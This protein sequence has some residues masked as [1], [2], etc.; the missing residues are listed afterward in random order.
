MTKKTCTTLRLAA[1]LLTILT[2]VVAAASSQAAVII[3]R[4]D[5]PTVGLPGFTTVTLT[6]S[7]DNGSNI[8]GFDFASKPSYGFFGPMNQVNPAGGATVF[9]D[10]NA[11]FAFLEPPVDLSRDSQFKFF[12]SQLT[13]PGGFASESN[14]K[15]RA[16][17]ASGVSLGASL[18]FVQLVIPEAAA[19]TVNYVGQ[20]QTIFGSGLPLDNNVSGSIPVPIPEPASAALVGL[21]VAIIGSCC[22]RQRNRQGVSTSLVARSLPQALAA[23]CVVM[24]IVMPARAVVI[25]SQSSSPTVGLPGFTTYTMTAT[26][27]TGS[28][29]G[30]DFASQPTF[31][32]FGPALNQIN[33]V[34][35]PTIFRENN[36]IFPFIGADPSQDSQF[37]FASSALT[38]PAGFA[39]ESNV[40]LRAVFAAGAPLG[41]SVQFAQLALPNSGG[42][43]QFQGQIQTVVG[44]VVSDNNVSGGCIFLGCGLSPPQMVDDIINNVNPNAPGLLTHTISASQIA[45]LSNFKFDSY[46][47]APGFSGT[48]PATAA[49]LNLSTREFRWNTV[50]SAPGTYKW[51]MT[52]GNT[53]G[54]DNGSLTV[55]VIPEPASAALAGLVVAIIA[56]N[57]RRRRPCRD[58]STSAAARSLTPAVAVLGV[59]SAILTFT[60]AAH[61]AVIIT[62]SGAPTVGLPNYTTY[63][64]TAT[65][66]IG[67]IQGFDFASQPSFGFFGAMNQ[68]NPAGI[69]TIFTDANAFFPF[70]GADVSQDSQ[71]KFASNAV[72]VPAGFASESA[73]SLRAVF[74]AS[75]PIGA[76][77]PF[78]QLAIPNSSGFFNFVGQIQTVVGGSVIDNNVTGSNCLGCVPPQIV[79]ATINNVNANNPGFVEHTV[80][81]NGIAGTLG[82]F[83]FD[84]FVPPLG[85]S[86]TGP[87]TPATLNTSTRK[88]NWNTIGSPLGTYKWTFTATNNFGFDNGSITVNITVPEP[89]TC[90]LL[91]LSLAGC[92]ALIRRR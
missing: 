64:L 41:S 16:I 32:F 21:V 40:H 35:L 6:A 90:S 62:S 12:T 7:T 17:F 58:N 19:A 60:P 28:I 55:N 31:G 18:P 46:V 88:F 9:Q 4:S 92:L 66:D 67:Q 69:A 51:T 75:A 3:S 77:V 15:L 44:N 49:N 24:V 45:A 87:A 59:A 42:I 56:G 70:V 63:T 53:A 74:A 22:R 76:S 14:S 11:F 38:V 61:A 37:A 8:Y 81:F 65:T 57:S 84:S 29:Q 48:G 80:Q 43:Y 68:V 30:F 89:A 78:V 50:G 25:I 2:M 1:T 73:T 33:P 52:A 23:L 79:D 91:A 36:A 85:G 71:F 72:T 13:I 27:D 5:S 34:G 86:G 26:T 54:F 47:P 82:N 10:L 83:A 20:I 39:S